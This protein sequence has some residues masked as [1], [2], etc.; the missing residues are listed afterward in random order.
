ML[1]H[2]FLQFWAWFETT[3]G[4]SFSLSSL[5]HHYFSVTY[6]G[7]IIFSFSFIY[8]AVCWLALFDPSQSFIAYYKLFSLQWNANCHL[9]GTTMSFAFRCLILCQQLAIVILLTFPSFIPC[10]WLLYLICNLLSNISWMCQCPYGIGR[11]IG[12]VPSAKVLSQPMMV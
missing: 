11:L 4:N 2:L 7:V 5:E 6:F 10:H 8:F 3:W 1:H 9:A 12:S